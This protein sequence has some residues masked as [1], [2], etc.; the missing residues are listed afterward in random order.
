M[1]NSAFELFSPISDL[2]QFVMLKMGYLMT[3]SHSGF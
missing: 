2:F 1:A 3:G